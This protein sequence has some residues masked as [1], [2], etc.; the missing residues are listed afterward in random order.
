MANVKFNYFLKSKFNNQNQQ[1]IVLTIT[2]G[3][4]RTQVF[5]GLWIASS[6]WN[7]RTKRLKGLD[8]ESKTIN[9]TL[10][11]LLS[12]ARQVSNEILVSGQPFNP[13][14]IKEKLKNGFRKNLGVIEAFVLFLERMEKLIP[15]KY[16]RSTLVKYTNTKVRVQE[17]I[18][19]K[20]RRNDIYLYELDTMFMEDF[21]LW[22]RETYKVSHNTIYKTWQRFSRFLKFEISRGNLDKYPFIDYDIK[23]EVKQGHYLTYED[24]Q[25][26]ENLEIDLPRL[27]Q[28]QLLWIFCVYTGLAYADLEKAKETDLQIDANGVYWLKAFRQKSKTRVS[29]PLISNAIR[30]MDL[31]RNGDFEIK[32]GRLLPV[33]SNVRLNYEIKQLASMARVDKPELL[34]WHVARRSTSSLMMQAD[35]PL[36][37]L[38]KVLSHKSLS[39][40]LQFYSHVD[41]TQVSS[42][43]KLLDERLNGK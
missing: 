36:Q 19:K 32:K 11:T 15:S 39:T 17:F 35:I 2:M 10:L 34:T 8:D 25:K 33:K 28:V 41:D 40:S 14:T 20:I 12:K 16:T 1:P 22:L 7:N 9:D 26:I 38:Q 21:D 29:V 24:I 6:K 4:D 42:A 13:N 18:K 5:T 30:C 37:I 31:L 43:M 23:M 27:K 3:Y